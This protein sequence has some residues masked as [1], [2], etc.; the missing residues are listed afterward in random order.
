VA[1][2]PNGQLLASG[3]ADGRILVWQVSDGSLKANLTAGDQ[4]VLQT[5][6]APDDK[7]LYSLSLDGALRVWTVP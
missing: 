6:F 5:A 1:F 2:S 4:E 7:T 3:T